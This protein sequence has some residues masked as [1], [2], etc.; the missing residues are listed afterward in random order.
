[1]ENV[2]PVKAL[3]QA[4][5]LRVWGARE[6]PLFTALWEAVR[7]EAVRDIPVDQPPAADQEVRARELAA[8]LRR[9]PG[10]IIAQQFVDA[11]GLTAE[12]GI[13]KALT[14]FYHPLAFTT[15]GRDLVAVANGGVLYWIAKDAAYY[16]PAQFLEQGVR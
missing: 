7:A 13:R 6:N 5:R 10:G 15:T 3:V 1:M 2:H 9:A 16:L 11:C 8:I 14:R 12:E 4:A